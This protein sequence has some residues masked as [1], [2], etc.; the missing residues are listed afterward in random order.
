M[1]L[2][3]YLHDIASAVSSPLHQ[4]GSKSIDHQQVLPGTE[5]LEKLA[6][7]TEPVGYLICQTFPT[8]NIKIQGCTSRAFLV[9][10]QQEQEGM[11]RP[12][13][14]AN[15]LKP[16]RATKFPFVHPFY[17]SRNQVTKLQSSPSTLQ[18][19]SPKNLLARI[20][21]T[22]SQEQRVT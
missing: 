20:F 2:Q 4:P 19:I 7:S 10:S 3:T 14:R 5:E 6:T 11:S 15:I 16:T 9:N 8:K 12:L 21:T 18:H 1:S 13:L 17:C 22:N